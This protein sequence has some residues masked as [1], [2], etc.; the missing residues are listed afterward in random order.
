MNNRVVVYDSN[1]DREE[2]ILTEEA[3]LNAV[4][5]LAGR[6]VLV[7]IGFDV[8]NPVGKAF[9]FEVQNG[10]LLATIDVT[11]DVTEKFFTIGGT[12]YE[13]GD[14]TISEVGTTDDPSWGPENE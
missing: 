1:T 7:T 11:P 13:N 5:N 9:D 3:L 12:L 2:P 6:S 8:T 14:L 4:E 10:K